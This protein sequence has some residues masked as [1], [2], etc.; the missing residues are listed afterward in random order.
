[1][2]AGESS[3]TAPEVRAH[4]PERRRKKSVVLC[5]CCCSC[6]CCCCLHSL[7]GALGSALVN[8]HIDV[9]DW[10]P[11]DVTDRKTVTGRPIYQIV[12]LVMTA[13]VVFGAHV[14]VLIDRKP[15]LND[16]TATLAV[17]LVIL[18]LVFPAFQFT[19]A[20]LAI[21]GA[22]LFSRP[23]LKGLY[24]RS[25]AR[26]LAGITVGSLIGLVLTV[27]VLGLLILGMK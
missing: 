1:M 18:L 3:E 10:V 5:G 26:I 24:F 27:A 22:A 19:A 13:V 23:E 7:G 12:L 17:E 8:S 9:P 4:P 14:Y 21:I 15:K 20:I 6:C 16:W 11:L 25:I 2:S